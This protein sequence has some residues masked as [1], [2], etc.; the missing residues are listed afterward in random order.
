M[1]FAGLAPPPFAATH[2]IAREALTATPRS[3]RTPSAT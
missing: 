1:T 3:R 2:A